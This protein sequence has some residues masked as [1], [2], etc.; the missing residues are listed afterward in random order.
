MRKLTTAGLALGL[1]SAVAGGAVATAS[2]VAAPAATVTAGPDVYVLTTDNVLSRFGRTNNDPFGLERRDTVR[3]LL[4]GEN[5][6]GLDA[7]PATGRLYAL[8]DQGRL[9]VL[10]GPRAT[11][12]GTGPIVVPP[13]AP[14]PSSSVSAAPTPSAPPQ[15]G[16][17]GAT[18]IGIDF[19]PTVDLIRVTVADGRNFRIDPDDGT[20]VGLDSNLSYVDQNAGT[21]PEVTGLGYTNDPGA[22][23]LFGID[24]GRD[25]LVVQGSVAGEPG[26]VVSPNTGRLRTVGRLGV[27]VNAINGF[28]VA[29]VGT[30]P[31][32][33]PSRYEAIV[34]SSTFSQQR[35]TLFSVNLRTGRARGVAEVPGQVIGLTFAIG[36]TASPSSSVSPSVSVSPSTP[37]LD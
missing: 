8:S 5:L 7:R 1:A 13:P 3:G 36:A 28:D 9:Y 33:D 2:A 27:N 14:S 26:P 29:G 20:V 10:T 18:A 34:S 12:V 24:S 31:V 37:P 16:P 15:Q 30:G 4:P 21:A 11:L 19:N 35:S 6:I 17:E 32:F 22:T 25:T 23:T